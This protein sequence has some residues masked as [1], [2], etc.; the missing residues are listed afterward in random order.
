MITLPKNIKRSKRRLSRLEKQFY[1]KYPHVT[2]CLGHT[3]VITPNMLETIR[4][5]NPMYNPEWLESFWPEGTI[6]DVVGLG[7]DGRIRLAQKN[8]VRT[9][10]IKQENLK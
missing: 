4:Q 9:I 6:A 3:V 2:L 10:I 7:L 5:S 1:R 8:T